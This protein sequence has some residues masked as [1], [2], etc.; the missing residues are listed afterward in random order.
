[1]AR[2]GGVACP[3]G[4]CAHQVHHPQ[5]LFAQVILK[6]SEKNRIKFSEQSENFDFSA[7]FLLHG[8][9]RKQTK[10]G[11]LFYL[12]SKNRKLKII[13]ESCVYSIHQRHSSQR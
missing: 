6:N 13:T 7:A 11:I 8:K 3:G 2:H 1:M 5:V 9:N 4:Y 12:T 10:H